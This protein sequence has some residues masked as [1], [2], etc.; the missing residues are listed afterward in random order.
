MTRIR[1]PY[2]TQHDKFLP[3]LAEPIDAYTLA[4]RVGTTFTGCE[5]ALRAMHRRGLVRKI[6]RREKGEFVAHKWVRA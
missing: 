5:S 3:H 4:E 6:V 1:K 2:P